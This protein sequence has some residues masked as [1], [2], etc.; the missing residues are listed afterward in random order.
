[1]LKQ[2]YK[3]ESGQSLGRQ[4]RSVRHHWKLL[5][6]GSLTMADYMD[7]MHSASSSESSKGTSLL[8]RKQ[9]ELTRDLHVV[10]ESTTKTQK[11]EASGTPGAFLR[12]AQSESATY[13][14]L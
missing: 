8:G 11:L 2:K 1:M 14:D 6:C 13:G 3:I 10:D 9:G 12:K 7:M 4:S 5:N